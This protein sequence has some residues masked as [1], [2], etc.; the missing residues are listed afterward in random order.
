VGAGTAAYG[1]L[2]GRRDYVIEEVVVPIPGLPRAL[3]G[4]T[5]VQLS[6]L[7]I[8]QFVTERE[9]AAAAMLVR[10]AR[11]D[12]VVLTGDLLDHDERFAPLL[13]GLARRLGALAR[14]GVVAIPGNHDYY[15]GVEATLGALRSAGARVLVNDGLVIGE[16]K[17]GLALLGVDDVWAMRRR[18]G[19]G[20]DLQRAIAKV[21]RDL[22]RVLLCHNPVFFPDAAADVAL[23]LSGHTHGGQVNLLVRPADVVLPHGYV[24]G[25]YQR[26]GSRL[27]VNRGFGTA[28]PPMRV[29]APPEITR[30]VLVGA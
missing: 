16:A 26:D 25:L 18:Q 15:A 11:P 3:E 19:R 5:L 13:G 10:D 7:H 24:A 8:G 23:Q 12:V 4:F 9:L 22:P 2:I 17:S 20:P 6:D 14:E 27:Y 28:G 1:G 29:G 30:V 21:P